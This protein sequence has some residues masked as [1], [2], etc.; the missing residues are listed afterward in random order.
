[1]IVPAPVE[2]GRGRSR[3][4]S[5]SRSP[6]RSPR[7]PP[8][9][10]RI[11][12]R[13]SRSPSPRRRSRSRS[14]SSSRSW[15]RCRRRSVTPPGYLNTVTY[16]PG[17]PRSPSPSYTIQPPII[18]PQQQ[19]PIVV[20]PQPSP[21]L[22]S[23]WYKQPVDILT[24][25]YNKNMAYAPAAKTYDEAI[26]NVV[27]LWPELR[28]VERDRIHLLVT[29]SD[30]LVR[31]PRMTWT[32]VLCDLPRYEVVHVQVEELPPPPQ[33]QGKGKGKWGDSDGKG[34]RSSGLFSSIRRIFFG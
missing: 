20:V 24:F 1:M 8:S 32:A 16:R 27:E 7:R 19:L 11:Y 14:R 23:S 26:D 25:H 34:R 30:H 4:R 6:S 13:Y 17:P 31:V 2:E 3:S 9:P 22:P 21:P 29:G 12:S 33:Y 28:E 10:V 18:L 5:R 15:R